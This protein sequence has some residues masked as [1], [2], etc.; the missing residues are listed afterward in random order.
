M[1]EEMFQSIASQLRQPH[2]EYA[3]EVG[4]RMNEGN[5]QI[6]MFT[7]ETLHAEAGD[8]IL[9]IG[10]GNGLFVKNI[11]STSPS[12]HYTGCDYS[13]IM[14]EQAIQRNAAFIKLG[15]ARFYNTNAEELPFDDAQFNKVFSVNTIYFWD[16]PELILSE[17]YRVLKPQGKFIIS[18]RPKSSMQYYPFVKYGF[19]MFTKEDLVNLLSENNFKVT[20]VLEKEEPP[21]EMN[22]ELVKVETLIVCAEKE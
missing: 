21:Q 8:H 4:E 20:T 11:L 15:Q 14:I 5:F 12:I 7:I 1:N 19:C 10:G 2:G 22:G 6:N 9:E 13:E 16:K 17:V 18:L 3:I